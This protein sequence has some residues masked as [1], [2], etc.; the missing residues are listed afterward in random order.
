MST[1]W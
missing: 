1:W